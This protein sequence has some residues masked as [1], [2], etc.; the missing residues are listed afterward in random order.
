MLIF[1]IVSFYLQNCSVSSDLL[2]RVRGEGF[3]VV[4]DPPGDGICFFYAA[5]H[6]LDMSATTA[7][8]IYIVYLHRHRY[9][10]CTFFVF[11]KK[12]VRH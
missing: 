8:N 12:E 11:M 7:Q 6:Q 5:T 1:A 10:V 2:Q 9:E 3:E 4:L